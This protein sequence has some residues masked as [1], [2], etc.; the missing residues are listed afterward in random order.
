MG[1]QIQILFYKEIDP[2]KWN[3]CIDNSSNS[4]IYARY[5]YLTK[6]C[7]NWSGLIINDYKTV[8][9]LP[10]K[11]KWGIRYL[12]APP[13]IQQLGFFGNLSGLPIPQVIDRIKEY[14]KFGDLF[15]NYQNIELL[16]NINYVEK[17]NFILNL[18]HSYPKIYNNYSQD[19]VKNLQR[20][21][22]HNLQYIQS[23]SI[24][25][26][27]EQFQINYQNRFP[28]Y[29]ATSFQNLKATC[30]ELANKNQCFTR[31]VCADATKQVIST[32]LL[33][34]DNTRLYLLINSTNTTGRSLSANHFLLD[35][36]IQEFCEESLI[37]D[38]EGSER[39]GIKDFYQSFHPINQPYFHYRFNNLPFLINLVRNMIQTLKFMFQKN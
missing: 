2:E 15:F 14:V 28:Q 3:N 16:K 5:Q 1:T 26:T 33:L 8:L 12:Y 29:N 13:F 4:L 25:N 23:V 6:Q 17:T 34:K 18:N 36:I 19:L 10:W 30:K 35:S 22:K 9:P 39:K 20:S 31:S 11:K 38:F 27:I 24:E 21:E 32:A 7:N 37:L